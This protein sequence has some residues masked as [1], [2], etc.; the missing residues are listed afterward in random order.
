MIKAIFFDFDG[1]LA[2]TA[3]AIIKTAQES[4]RMMGL[5]VPDDETVRQTIGIPLTQALQLQGG[6]S[7]EDAHRAA[8]IYADN[9]LSFE[10]PLVKVFPNVKETLEELRKAGLR[11]AICTSRNVESLNYI[12]KHRG[13]DG[14]FEEQV[15]NNDHLTPKPAPD[16]VLALLERMGLEKEEVLVVGDTT[17]DIEMGN[18]AGCRTVA[19]TYGNHSREQVMSASPTWVIDDIQQLIGIVNEAN[20]I[21]IADAQRMVDEWIHE[22]GVR[23]FSELTNMACLTE[24]VGELAR[25]MARK[26]GD[27]SFKAG[28]PTDPSDEMADVLW[29]LLCLANQTGIDLT[30]AFRRNMQKKTNRDK[31][32]HKNNPKLQ[33]DTKC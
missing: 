13:L 20:S 9:F 22:Y 12:L 8:S 17:F 24:E 31:L 6:L 15:T 18:R 32:R 29:V 16:M 23:Y 7:D 26:Y 27:Q 19:V 33:E 5:P 11:M 1:T 14:F 3:P 30:E 28:E 2:D 10:G 4:F 21:S 25:I